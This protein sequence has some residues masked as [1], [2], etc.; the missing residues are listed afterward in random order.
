[1]RLLPDVS[2]GVA[3]AAVVVLFVPFAVHC[4][5]TRRGD[6]GRVPVPQTLQI[7]AAAALCSFMAG[8]HVHEKSIL[9]SVM[10]LLPVAVALPAW[11]G[12]YAAFRCSVPDVILIVRSIEHL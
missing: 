11:R 8:Y 12:F 2:A 7:M 9:I 5:T 1:M 4:V 3:A 6:A 10:M